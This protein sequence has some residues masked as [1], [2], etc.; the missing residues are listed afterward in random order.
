M[1]DG[2]RHP[3]SRPENIQM[4]VDRIGGVR[5]YASA[6]GMAQSTVRRWLQGTV[7]T[8]R[9]QRAIGKIHA[10]HATPV[11]A[12]KVYLELDALVTMLHEELV[13]LSL[14]GSY[15]KRYIVQL[16]QNARTARYWRDDYRYAARKKLCSSH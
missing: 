2:P 8:E 7:P 6:V 5:L 14:D 9:K 13:D 10:V 16:R 1:S 15:P 3:A 12:Q 11:E 4:V